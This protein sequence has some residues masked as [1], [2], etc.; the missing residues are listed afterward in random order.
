MPRG[1]PDFSEFAQAGRL[2][3]MKLHVTEIKEPGPEDGQALPV[4]H[5]KGIARAIDDSTLNAHSEIQG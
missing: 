3:V 2:I 4:V 5:F 1:H